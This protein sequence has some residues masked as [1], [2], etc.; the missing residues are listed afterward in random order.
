MVEIYGKKFTK[1]KW[2]SV[3][4]GYKISLMVEFVP[5]YLY[6]ISTV[7]VF[8]HFKISKTVGWVTRFQRRSVLFCYEISMTVGF[9]RL[10]D[11]S[12]GRFCSFV[13]LQDFKDGRLGNEI[14]KTV[15]FVLL[16]VF[17]DGRFCSCV[18]LWL[19]KDGLFFPGSLMMVKIYGKKLRNF[20]DGR[21]CSVMRSQWL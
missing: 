6:E 12:D 10:W 17:Y 9:V 18:P 7:V 8:F 11:L 3:L 13:H 14:S 21:F 16:W 15:S 2:W 20:N 1:F 4:F 5:L 19:F